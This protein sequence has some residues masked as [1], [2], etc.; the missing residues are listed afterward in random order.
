MVADSIIE[1]IV[2]KVCF[3]NRLQRIFDSVAAII[4][5]ANILTILFLIVNFF[6]GKLIFSSIIFVTIINL[7]AIIFGII[8]AI[9]RFDSKSKQLVDSAILIDRHYGFKDRV[10]TAIQICRNNNE[11]TPMMQIQLEDTAN[12]LSR[13]NLSETVKFRASFR[14]ALMI[15]FALISY[16]LALSSDSDLLVNSVDIKSQQHL[17]S[18]DGKSNDNNQNKNEGNDNVNTRNIVD[19]IRNNKDRIDSLTS[20]EQINQNERNGTLDKLRSVCKR[21][22]GEIERNIKRLEKSASVEESVLAL[23]EIE[24]SVRLAVSELDL[25]S[26]KLS[27][28]SMASAFENAEILRSAAL[29]IKNENYTNT[30]KELESLTNENFDSMTRIERKSVSEGL[31]DAADEMQSRNQNDLEQLTRKFADEIEN[32]QKNSKTTAEQIAKNYR[33]QV[34]RNNL[35]AN[36][37]RQLSEI[38]KYKSQLIDSYNQELSKINNSDDGLFSNANNYNDNNNSNNGGGNGIGNNYGGNPQGQNEIEIEKK[39]WSNI[40][41][42][43]IELSN[44]SSSKDESNRLVKVEVLPETNLSRTSEYEYKNLY[45]HY[46]NRA[47]SVLKLESIPFGYRRTIR[48]YFDSIKPID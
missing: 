12:Y 3:R 11:I 1:F 44:I 43:K 14:Y 22:S 27:F 13:I 34:I 29:E 24:Q 45:L 5:C 20:D 32:N 42:T 46:R 15:I 25:Q 40:S 38:N 6:A 35:H 8:F 16:S 19:N 30:A 7:L 26:Y 47:E 2:E 39:N 41:V 37:S 17:I 33:R 36:L 31:Q 21:L 23:S 18:N 9:F 28:Q 4:L 10:L 48:G